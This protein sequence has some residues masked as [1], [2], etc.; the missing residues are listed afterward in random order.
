MT[1]KLL[2][3]TQI[4]IVPNMKTCLYNVLL[5]F[6][7]VLMV[8][9]ANRGRPTGGPKDVAPPEIIRSVPENFSTNFKGDEIR[10]YFNEYIKV[11]NIQ[12]QLIISPPMDPAP[13]I[14][15]L[16]TASKYIAIKITDTLAPNTTYA[17]NFGNS[18]VDNN[19][20]NPYPYYRY[21]ISTGDYIDSLSV[22]G[23]IIDATL[24][25]PEDFIS[26]MLYEIDSTYTDSIVYKQNPKYITNTLDSTTTFSID[27]IKKGNYLLV[28]MKDENQDNKFQQ[29]TDKIGF[30]DAFITVPSDSSYTL[31]LF[32]EKL[33]DK[34]I[35]P[36]LVSGE[37][38][39]FGYEGD[40]KNL[41][42]ELLSKVPD[43]FN[44]RITKD[45]KTDSLNYWYVPRLKTDSL[46]FNVSNHKNYT[47]TFTVKLSE[48]PRDTLTL[49]AK[50]NGDIGFNEDFSISGSTPLVRFNQKQLTIIDKDST[51]IDFA[52]AFDTLTN[53][54]T[55]KFEKTESN[56]YRINMLP[57]AMVDL[58]GNTNDTLNYSISTKALSNYSNVR[59]VLQNATYP[60]IIQLTDN[61]GKVTHEMYSEQAAPVDFRNITPGTYFLRVVF[62]TNKNQKFDSGNF[63]KKQQPERISHYPEALDVRAGWDLVQEFTLSR[64]D[65][66]PSEN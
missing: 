61:K 26:V 1:N 24:R 33:D 47:E 62:D 46:L 65:L 11:N 57:N 13:E 21:V 38:I 18:I 15:P 23:N 16:G 35:R 14:T 2:L 28:A 52:T 44:Y 22:T 60:V 51:H 5:A 3:C 66:D 29:K 31:K 53:T 45:P 63:L 49:T 7:L 4:S 55:F 58:F 6:S 20:G 9:C 39:A 30:H 34:V 17:F 42:I 37:K 25:Q 40:Y 27:N 54:Y 10:I 19:E 8:N 43:S 12:K 64:S 48:Q 41:N 32:K 56:Q 50:P 59:V 36:R